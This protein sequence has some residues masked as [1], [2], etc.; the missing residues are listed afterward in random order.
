MLKY[1]IS[2]INYLAVRICLPSLVELSPAIERKPVVAEI[3]QKLG[4]EMT[5]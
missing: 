3:K 2:V 1:R 4:K 5:Q